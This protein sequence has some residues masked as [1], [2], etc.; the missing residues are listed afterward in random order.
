[1]WFHLASNLFPVKIIIVKGIV[2]FLFSLYKMCWL[3]IGLAVIRI[4]DLQRIIKYLSCSNFW[5]QIG[6]RALAKNAIIFFTL[7]CITWNNN[8]PY[9]YGRY[10]LTN[11]FYD[12][13]CF[14]AKYRWKESFWIMAIQRVYIYNMKIYLSISIQTNRFDIT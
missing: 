12:G 4:I 9:F 1:M 8:I 14:M 10:S 7:W 6:F 5:T 2:L 11:R 13:R 3:T